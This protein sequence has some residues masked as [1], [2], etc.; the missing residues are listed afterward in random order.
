MH[1]GLPPAEDV[2]R[3]KQ[4]GLDSDDQLD[5]RDKSS[6]N[7][8]EKREHVSKD[9]RNEAATFR[10]RDAAHLKKKHKLPSMVKPSPRE[11]SSAGRRPS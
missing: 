4:Y 6:T 5:A 1:G 7:I 3:W 10:V 8:S 11:A 2:E 9:F